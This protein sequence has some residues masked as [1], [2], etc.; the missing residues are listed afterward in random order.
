[1]SFS[2]SPGATPVPAAVLFRCLEELRDAGADAVQVGLVRIGVSS[3][4]LD[5]P[6]SRGIV[7]DGIVLAPPYRFLAIGDPRTLTAALEIP[8]GRCAG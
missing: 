2:P 3:Y 7:V 4:L 5:E 8:G 6:V 1:M